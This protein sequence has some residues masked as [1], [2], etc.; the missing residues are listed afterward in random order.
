MLLK[1]LLL[2]LGLILAVGTAVYFS[3]MMGVF[4]DAGEQRSLAVLSNCPENPQ[5]VDY[6]T[7]MR[8]FAASGSPDLSPDYALEIFDEYLSCKVPAIGASRF[9][10]VELEQYDA[11]ITSCA[12]SAY[13]KYQD[14][15]NSLISESEGNEEDERYYIEEKKMVERNYAEF[16]AIFR[17][18]S[19]TM[20]NAQVTGRVAQ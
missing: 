16:N 2:I 18:V 4:L 6:V 13:L 15:L 5:I 9:T 10:T 19:H 20:C 14:E 8:T 17:D 12:K 7:R 1:T 11:E 3:G